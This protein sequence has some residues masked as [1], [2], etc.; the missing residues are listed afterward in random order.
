MP[1][2]RLVLLSFLV[3]PV[4][5]ADWIEISRDAAGLLEIDRTSVT[6]QGEF[7]T[8]WDRFTASPGQSVLAAGDVEFRLEKTLMRYDCAR[9]TVV[10]LVRAFSQGDGAESLRLNV[11]GAEL[12]QPIVPDTPRDRM[13]AV[14]C[15][16]VAARAERGQDASSRG[17]DAG[18]QVTQGAVASGVSG[19]AGKSVVTENKTAPKRGVKANRPTALAPGATGAPKVRTAA[20]ARAE[21]VASSVALATDTTGSAT[22]RVGKDKPV[23]G[24]NKA[25]AAMS[26]PSVAVEDVRW[27]YSG[28]MG[29]ENWHKLSKAFAAC[30]EGKRQSPIDIRDGV[31]AQPTPITF[32]YKPSSLHVSNDGHTIRLLYDRGSNIV[33]NETTYELEQVHFHAP[34]EERVKGRT[35]DMAVHLEHRARDGGIA[36][37]AVLVILGEENDF[38]RKVWNHLPLDVGLVEKSTKV[39]I[40][41]GQLLPLIQGYY[42]YM[43][44]L[45]TPPCTEGVRWI[46]M[47][48][49]VRAS[50][51]QVQ[52]LS[53]VVDR[54]ARPVQAANGRLVKE[55]L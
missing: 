47:R 20:D 30:R 22:A 1:M 6:R 54:N 42:T 16:P 46:V 15:P 44:S 37:V 34:A 35:Y 52:T 5:A 19:R 3:L 49:P 25:T 11:E 17:T 24:A 51:A 31:K 14:A 12:P 33:V 36:I 48:T 27:S 28:P 26:A 43:G 55:V 53:R 18:S 23:A 4:E 45:T 13:L 2:F 10:P 38:I 40:D 29:V 8:A 41:A 21:A 39:K 7:A 32:N 9:R 50:R